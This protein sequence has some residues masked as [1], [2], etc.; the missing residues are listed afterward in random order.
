MYENHFHNQLKAKL[1]ECEAV[2]QIVRQT[3]IAP[4]EY[5]NRRGK[6]ARRIQDDAT[7]ARNLATAIY[8][9]AGSKTWTL[10]DKRHCVSY[11]GLVFNQTN[12]PKDATE[13]LLW[14]PDVPSHR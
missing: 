8:Y 3:T 13:A 14:R 7:I 11:I 1:L 4:L 2:T 5:L 12:N 10:A 9:N 6:P